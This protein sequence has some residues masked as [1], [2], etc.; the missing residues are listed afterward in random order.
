MKV[1]KAAKWRRRAGHLVVVATLAACSPLEQDKV[2]ARVNGEK[3]LAEEVDLALQ[4]KGVATHDPSARQRLIEK[5]VIE[6]LLAQQFLRGTPGSAVVEKSV[7]SAARREIL[8][9]SYIEIVIDGVKR[10]NADQM[11]AYYRDNPDMFARRRIFTLRQV[12]VSA[13]PARHAELRRRVAAAESLEALT[14]WL[15]RENIGFVRT[16]LEHGSDELDANVLAQLDGLKKGEVGLVDTSAGLRVIQLLRTL[17]API[18]ERAAWPSI[19]QRLWREMRVA[20]VEA[21]V[22]RLSALAAISIP[23]GAPRGAMQALVP[24]PDPPLVRQFTGGPPAS[25]KAPGG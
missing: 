6:E 3:I 4:Y 11:S 24:G 23:E 16:D 2:A 9:R 18:D 12:D 15:R 21:E 14:D 25:V 17:A 22:R 13:P 8:A 10:P 1:V 20:A 7:V 19:E 5:L